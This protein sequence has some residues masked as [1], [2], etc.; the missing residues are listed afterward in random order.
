[1]TGVEGL[2]HAAVEEGGEGRVEE[3]GGGC[4]GL[5]EEE[6]VGEDLRGATAEGEYDVGAAEGR[7]EGGRFELA[8]A[9]FAVG[10][11]DVRDGEAGAGFDVGIEVE[12]VP[13]E[14]LG[15]QAADGGL[16]GA[17]EAG[18]DEAA[19]VSGGARGDGWVRGG[20]GGDLG[21]H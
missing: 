15:E 21:V 16:A 20:L 2:H 12:E 8:E 17:H 19:E 10:G 18:E 5:L 4:G 1:M 13:A 6:A 9:G 7:G 14:A 3:D 11:E